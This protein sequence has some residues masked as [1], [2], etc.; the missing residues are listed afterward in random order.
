MM[1]DFAKEL[2]KFLVRKDDEV[3]FRIRTGNG[4]ENVSG[5]QPRSARSMAGDGA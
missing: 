1:N 5:I 2:T 3:E 4:A